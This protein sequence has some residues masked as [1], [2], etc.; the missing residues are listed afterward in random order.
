[1][2]NNPKN[3]NELLAMH[4]QHVDEQKKA[5][6][7]EDQELI[8]RRKEFLNHFK[9]LISS[10]IRP[11]MRDLSKQI[12]E[13]NHLMETP[14]EDHDRRIS[15]P[16]ISFSFKL[17]GNQRNTVVISFIGNFDH[18]KILIQTEYNTITQIKSSNDEYDIDLITGE[19]IENLLFVSFG[20]ILK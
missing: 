17:Y 7:Q 2:Q 13:Y 8:E 5:T 12:Q 16:H 1:M 3:L 18:E 15:H 19:F 6:K 11:K 20:K 10:T 4:K 9:R 14:Q